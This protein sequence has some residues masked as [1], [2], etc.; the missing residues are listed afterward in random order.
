MELFVSANSTTHTGNTENV[1][2]LVTFL[3]KN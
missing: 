3:F 1:A 2:S